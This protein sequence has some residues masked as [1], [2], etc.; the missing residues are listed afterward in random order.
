M[1]KVE[2]TRHP[3]ATY[4]GGLPRSSLHAVYESCEYTTQIIFRSLPTVAKH[5]V[6]RMVCLEADRPLDLA[7]VHAWC[8]RSSAAVEQEHDA[9]LRAM[10]DDFCLIVVEPPVATAAASS[11]RLPEDP[12]LRLAS[13]VRTGEAT[14]ALD[15]R[16]AASIRRGLQ[17]SAKLPWEEVRLHLAAKKPEKRPPTALVIDA[18]AERKWRALQRYLVQA[19]SRSQRTAESRRRAVAAAAAAASDSQ[20]DAEPRSR[21][22][23]R[24]E[25]DAAASASASSSA[26]AA[27]DASFSPKMELLLQSAELVRLEGGDSS[28]SSS[29]SSSAAASSSS[30]QGGRKLR[31]SAPSRRLLTAKGCDFLLQDEGVQLWVIL[32]E[33]LDT[34]CARRGFDRDDVL[35]FVCRLSFCVVGRGYPCK[36]LTLSQR[37]LLEEFTQLGFLYR[38][39]PTARWFYPTRLALALVQRPRA[40]SDAHGEV[41]GGSRGSELQLIIEHNF[42]LYA[43]TS[44]ELHAELLALFA[45]IE[46]ILPGFIVARITRTS[47]RN[48]ILEQRISARQICDFLSSHTLRRAES[49]AFAGVKVKYPGKWVESAAGGAC[50]PLPPNVRDKIVAWEKE[51][52]RVECVTDVVLY[53]ARASGDA[54][55]DARDFAQLVR[56][57]ESLGPNALRWHSATPPLMLA[58]EK[59]HASAIEAQIRAWKKRKDG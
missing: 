7:V 13:G 11:Q 15:H 14:V 19:T 12:R 43:Y 30:G 3:I 56:F 38:T 53:N 57:V 24:S 49:G 44:G 28:S 48:A 59:K 18:Y 55:A 20:D 4:F 9:A 26:A 42:R 29:S 6:L 35:S 25:M 36:A 47:V 31:L 54:A 16:F 5:Y 27:M 32:H 1:T 23:G 45:Q 40:G 8:R 39:S 46:Y 52:R 37:G 10:C 21:K 34:Q 58:V 41:H 33:Y 17:S 50:L 22:R 2:R 51:I